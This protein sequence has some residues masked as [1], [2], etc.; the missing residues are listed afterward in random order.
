M[1]AVAA[2]LCFSLMLLFAS[3]AN[4][5][6][7]RE[8][9]VA[10]AEMKVSVQQ[11]LDELALVFKNVLTAQNREPEDTES[12]GDFFKRTPPASHQLTSSVHFNDRG[13]VVTIDGC[14]VKWARQ[15]ESCFLFVNGGSV[16]SMRYTLEAAGHSEKGIVSIRMTFGNPF[17][18]K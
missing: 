12:L 14:P 4:P 8:T 7:R 3:C 6:S 17:E 15:F 11:E 16:S 18:E 9:K 2:V 10:K 1:Q 13:Q 5:S